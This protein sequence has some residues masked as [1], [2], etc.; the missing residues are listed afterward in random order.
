MNLRWKE[1]LALYNFKNNTNHTYDQFL[2]ELVDEDFNSAFDKCVD[3]IH[4]FDNLL[5]EDY[6]KAMKLK[7]SKYACLDSYLE[8]VE[9][10]YN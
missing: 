7:D 2:N 3:E 1:G 9:D 8:L 5:I 10:K 4:A 6:Q